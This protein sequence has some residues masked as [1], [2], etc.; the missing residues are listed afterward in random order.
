MSL[1]REYLNKG[2]S[3][4]ELETELLNLIKLYNQKKDT[5]LIVY[6]SAVSKSD[7]PGTLMEMDDYFTIFDLLRNVNKTKI[8]FY[9]ETPGGRGDA[10]EEI[11]KFLSS[12]PKS[13]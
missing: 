8:D 3:T 10:V 7:I 13:C 1:M 11:A 2:L 12:C 9:I 5:Y 4:D 6:A